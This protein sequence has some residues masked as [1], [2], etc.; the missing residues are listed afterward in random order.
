MHLLASYLLFWP[1][2]SLNL[3]IVRSGILHPVN[4]VERLASALRSLSARL[5]TGLPSPREGH[6]VRIAA[7]LSTG[8]LDTQPC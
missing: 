4:P 1:P 5:K 6:V 7:R 3:S 2:V 8:K